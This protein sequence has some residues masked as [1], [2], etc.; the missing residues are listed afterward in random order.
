MTLRP[1]T[2]RRRLLQQLGMA[3]GA[4]TVSSPVSAC[5]NSFPK[6]DIPELAKVLQQLIV[7]PDSAAVIGNAYLTRFNDERSSGVLTCRILAGLPAGGQRMDA[8]V[9]LE[10]IRADFECGDVVNL[11]GWVLSRTESRLCALYAI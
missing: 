5:R 6:T 9:L 7:H 4:A 11:R 3:L 8:Q 2:T 10:R 1:L